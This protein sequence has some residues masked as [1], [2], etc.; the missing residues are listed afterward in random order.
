VGA[1]EIVFAAAVEGHL[2]AL[3]LRDRRIVLDGI[4]ELLGSQP[5]LKT[6]NRKPMRPNDL[7]AWELR[8]GD[9]RVYYRID[10]SEPLVEVLAVG[11][12]RRE[13]I[14]IGGQRIDL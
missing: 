9:L 3:S 1:Y 6:R 2:K 13:Q 11:V 8:L 7:A 10:D 12:K 5:G 14:W 4:E